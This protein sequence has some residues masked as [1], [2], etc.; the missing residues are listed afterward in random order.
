MKQIRPAS[1]GPQADRNQLANGL[2]NN[3]ITVA[4]AVLLGSA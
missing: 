3:R 1:T 4:P 2:G